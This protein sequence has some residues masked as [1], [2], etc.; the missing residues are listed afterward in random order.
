MSSG[1]YKRRR[2]ILEHLEDGTISLLDL[3]VHD[4]LNLKA[5]LVIGNGSSLPPGVCRTSAAAIHAT[6]PRQISERAI[7]RSLE[8]LEG[9]G[10]IKRWNI[11]GKRGNYPVLVCR[12]SVHDL[13][14]NE[15][16]VD[17]TKT[18]DWKAPVLVPVGDLS[19]L[20]ELADAKLSGDREVRIKNREKSSDVVA[21]KA[22][23]PAD[24]RFKP[25]IE[26]AFIAY[27]GKYNYKPTWGTGEF[28]N[29]SKFLKQHP[30]IQYRDLSR[31]FT[32][33]LASESMYYTE[34]GHKL[35]VFLKDFD[36]LR[37]TD[38]TSRNGSPH[39]APRIPTAA[40]CRPNR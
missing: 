35:T 29:L 18:I 30:E 7:Q 12:A 25:F 8:H 39:S 5:N 17:G 28:T 1:Y 11:R 32:K 24:G 31:A 4:Y 15:H 20:R 2:G 27:E 36:G 26:F 10:W 6:C 40:D 9:I 23:P 33:Y 14:G 19:S 13:S 16:R 37:A 3:A 22:S 34:K 21:K 38:D